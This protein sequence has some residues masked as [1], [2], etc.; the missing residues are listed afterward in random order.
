MNKL[1]V[2]ATGSFTYGPGPFA[3]I[4]ASAQ[5]NLIASIAI[6]PTQPTST[7]QFVQNV[8]N[9]LISLPFPLIFLISLIAVSGFRHFKYKSLPS[10]LPPKLKDLYFEDDFTRT[11]ALYTG[12]ETKLE[13]I[14]IELQKVNSVSLILEI[15]DKVKRNDLNEGQALILLKKLGIP[16]NEINELLSPKIEN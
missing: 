4:S 1:K 7:R 8:K 10:S 12:F 6:D 16:N 3:S 11:I 9:F 15:I 5:P 14:K 2:I 13:E